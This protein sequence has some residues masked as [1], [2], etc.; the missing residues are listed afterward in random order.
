MERCR[1]VSDRQ[2]VFQCLGAFGAWA[3]TAPLQLGLSVWR[4]SVRRVDFDQLFRSED[5]AAA[6]CEAAK[7]GLVLWWRSGC[8]ERGPEALTGVSDG[9]TL[10]T[11][12]G[13]Q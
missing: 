4:V 1:S 3:G 13:C 11:R 5:A 8:A 2:G 9:I 6:C 12:G 10:L 7:E